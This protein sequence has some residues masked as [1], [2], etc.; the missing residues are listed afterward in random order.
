MTTRVNDLID[1]A[2]HLRKA[3]PGCGVEKMYYTLKPCFV[4]RDKFIDILMDAGF[5]LKWPP[6][7]RRTTYAG[8]TVYPNLIKGLKIS[9]PGSVWQSDITYIPIADRFYYAVFIID[10]YSKK[11]V[12]HKVSDSMRAMANFEALSMALRRHKPPTIHH[13][14]RGSQYGSLEY[15]GKL[16]Q[17]GCRISMGKIPQENAY[18]E[19]INGTIKNEYLNHKCPKTLEQLKL[20]VK[21]AVHHYNHDR[22]HNHLNRLTPVEFENKWFNDPNFSKPTITIFDDNSIKKPVNLF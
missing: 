9:S 10:V 15:T 2:H 21:K 5:R 17:T 14:D 8:K 19:R 18:A 16:K 20:F 7:Y 13:S 22:L 1:A 4:G 6:N 3:H 12:G 11:I